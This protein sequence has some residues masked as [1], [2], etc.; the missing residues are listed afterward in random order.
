MLDIWIW[1]DVNDL[2]IGGMVFDFWMLDDGNDL[3]IRGMVFLPQKLRDEGSRPT[4]QVNSAVHPVS[5]FP[6]WKF[7]R[8]GRNTCSAFRRPTLEIR[9]GMRE[10]LGLYALGSC[11]SIATTWA[12]SADS[13]LYTGSDRICAALGNHKCGTNAGVVA[14]MCAGCRR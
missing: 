13:I 2:G 4:K 14:A 12:L 1:D 10:K 8:R 9:I 3:G 5:G 11:L 7:E 6:E